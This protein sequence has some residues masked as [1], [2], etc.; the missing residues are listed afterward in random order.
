MRQII[1]AL[2]ILIILGSN[3][4]F[5]TPTNKFVFNQTYGT[6]LSYKAGHYDSAVDSETVR[7]L[8]ESGADTSALFVGGNLT[9][10][11]DLGDTDGGGLAGK[12]LMSVV[13]TCAD[14][15]GAEREMQVIFR[16]GL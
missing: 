3:A 15:S 1:P 12:R 2:A 6:D 16:F 9:N 8:D 14:A 5:A 4:V 11:R 13:A 10:Y 7:V